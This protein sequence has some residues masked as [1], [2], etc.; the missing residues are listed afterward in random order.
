MLALARLFLARDGVSGDEHVA[1]DFDQDMLRAMRIS[2]NGAKKG[3]EIPEN[4]ALA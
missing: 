2:S 3:G 4:L 1:I